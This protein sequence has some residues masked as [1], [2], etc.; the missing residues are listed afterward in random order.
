MGFFPHYDCN[1]SIFFIQYKN[2]IQ[3]ISLRPTISVAAY[4]AQSE[5]A[6]PRQEGAI[7]KKIL[8]II[9]LFSNIITA[10]IDIDT[11]DNDEISQLDQQEFR[12]DNIV[13]KP[14]TTW[15]KPVILDASYPTNT[16]TL[17]S[18]TIYKPAPFYNYPQ[19]YSSYPAAIIIA[20]DNITVDLAGCNLSLDPSSAGNFLLNN[21]TYG[22]SVYQGVK[23]VRIV[24]STPIQKGSI[25]GFSGAAIYING[26]AQSFNNYD[27]YSNMVKNVTI[28]NLLITQNINGIYIAN[29]LRANV[30]DTD[31]IYN[32]SARVVYGIYCSNIL[33]GLIQNCQ[34][35]QNLSFTDIYGIYLN[36]TTNFTVKNSQMNGNRSFQNGNATGLLIT[37]SS[38]LTSTANQISNCFANR[39]LCSFVTGK[40]CIGFN[41]NNLSHHNVIERCNAY[42]CT[43]GPLYPGTTTPVT[44]PQ[45]IGFQID[46]GQF[47]QM[48]SNRSGYNDT[49]GFYDTAAISSSFWTNNT[50][51]LNTTANYNV[52]VPTSTGSE[53]LPTIILYPNDL[54]AYVGSG[55]VLENIEV[56]LP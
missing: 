13:Q 52:T 12:L 15:T 18:N 19:T 43:H 51:I 47:T 10:E 4:K 55:P 56:Q 49:Y 7:M 32:Y 16:Y 26:S 44:Y 30:I 41:I 20:K 9:L 14:T 53:P 28:L 29:A 54:T 39:N 35:D 34:I 22:I 1:V 36:D 46:T 6:M 24:S 38:A 37:A 17:E 33:E 8:C 40:K 25:S 50:G 5:R 23:N 27:I 42:A 31:I 21:P 11:E 45:G 3:K 2:E 48:D